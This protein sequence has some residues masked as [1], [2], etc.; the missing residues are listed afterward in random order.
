MLG[1]D[2]LRKAYLSPTFR[3]GTATRAISIS[4]TPG[5]AITVTLSWIADVYLNTQLDVEI[6]FDGGTTWVIAKNNATATGFIIASVPG[7]Y[8]ILVRFCFYSTRLDIA[9]VLESFNATVHQQPSLYSVAFL[10]LQDYGLNLNTDFW[11]DPELFD[12]LI[13]YGWIDPI[14]Y[15]DALKLIVTAAL[16]YVYV[17]RNNIIRIEGSDYLE[18]YRASSVKTIS[19][20][21]YFERANPDV[22]DSIKNS[23]AVTTQPLEPDATSQVY[24]AQIDVA[25]GTSVTVTVKYTKTPVQ[26]A[27]A[28]LTTPPTGCNITSE[29][30]YTW[31]AIVTISNTDTSDHTVTLDIEG[32][33]LT[34][35]NSTVVEEIDSASI[36]DFGEIVYQ[37]PNNS[38]VQSTAIA[39]LIA[40]KLVASMSNARRDMSMA[41][42]GNP[43]IDIGDKIKTDDSRT[44]QAFYWITHREITFDGSYK[45]SINGRLAQ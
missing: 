39:K 21:E 35:K 9:P 36:R 27:A 28:T 10:V 34:V 40:Q 31:G 29:T 25:K 32:E 17:D 38:F 23:V 19:R 8:D 1:K 43:A 12:F 6:S 44:S 14:T 41:W 13:D 45:E 30:Y 4:Y 15:R 11:I 24:G 20:S 26:N 16:A 5:L 7:S 2:I 18:T 33:Q 37:F 42:R 3:F 22:W